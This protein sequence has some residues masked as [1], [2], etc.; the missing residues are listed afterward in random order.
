MTADTI[1]IPGVLPVQ[2]L[3]A[4]GI[5]QSRLEILRILLSQRETTTAELIGETGLSMNGVRQHLQALVGCGL[6]EGRRAT[7]PRGA[8][9]ITYWRAAADHIEDQMD[10]LCRYLLA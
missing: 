6:V 9:P 8:G 3:A 1:T 10:Q 5:T 7:H 4:L 2:I